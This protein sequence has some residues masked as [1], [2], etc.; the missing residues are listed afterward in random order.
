MLRKERQGKILAILKQEKRVIIKE[1]AQRLGVSV[2]TIRRDFDE[3]SGSGRIKKV[4]GGAVL[5]DIAPVQQGQPLFSARIHRQ[6]AE[7]IH[8]AQAAAALVQE[9]DVIVLDIGTT[10]LEVARQVKDFSNITVLTNSVPILVELMD[11]ELEI[12]SLGGRLRSKQQALYGSIALKS[13]EDFCVNKAFISAANITLENGLTGVHRDSAELCSAIIQ[14]ADQAI[15]VADS[16]KFE[17]NSLAVIG[18]LEC[19]DTIITDSG[20][21]KRYADE[22]RARGIRLIIV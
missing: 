9:N 11:S 5:P 12:Y 4:Y 7:K 14:R 16:S 15:L 3:L 8:I 21:S 1:L 10:C 18:P 17:K 2:I 22:I 6:R 13:M 20:I 19:V